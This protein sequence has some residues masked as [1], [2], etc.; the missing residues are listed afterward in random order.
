MK[1][2]TGPH[3]FGLVSAP[4]LNTLVSDNGSNCL[5]IAESQSA[6]KKPRAAILALVL[7]AISA[8][9]AAIPVSHA[10]YQQMHR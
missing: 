8:S 2:L 1:P 10:I 4:L 9:F 6:S 3:A 7:I 5:K